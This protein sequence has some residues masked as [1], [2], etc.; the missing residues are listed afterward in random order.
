M[1]AK[2]LI[3][4]DFDDTVT[5]EDVSL[6]ILEEFAGLSW[7]GL[8]Q[9]YTEGKI[10]VGE[11]NEGAFGK[12]KAGRRKILDFI[13]KKYKVRPGFSQFIRFCREKGHRVVIVSNGLDFYID[14]ILKCSRLTDIEYHAAKTVFDPKGLRVRY[15]SHDGVV[16]D[17]DF[18][19]SYTRL[20][21]NQGYRIAY[22]GDGDS[23]F[24]PAQQCERIFATNG[25]LKHCRENNVTCTP[26]RDFHTIVT[27]L[28][29]W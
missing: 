27:A 20:F 3:Q 2:T 14:E 24:V 25:L 13:E 8:W 1:T 9:E 10:T 5:C 23:D 16:L 22:V 15:V 12:V 17:K 19:L 21:L 6:L 4:C 7:H 26:F 29:S 28:D 18:K 11:F